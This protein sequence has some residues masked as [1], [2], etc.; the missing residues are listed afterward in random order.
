MPERRKNSTH[1]AG[2][3][4][5]IVM[6]YLVCN[7]PRLVL[8]MAEYQLYPSVYG[9]DD[10][11]CSLTP[12]WFRVL[13]RISHLLLTLNSSIN[14]IIY[15]SIGKRFKKIVWDQMTLC[16]NRNRMISTNGMNQRL[17]EDVPLLFYSSICDKCSKSQ[18]MNELPNIPSTIGLVRTHSLPT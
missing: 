16:G 15:I 7:V 8:N 17:A 4:T 13:C 11:G 5:A 6:M 14:F 1:S 2:T 18:S 12:T 9:L 10:C 3:L